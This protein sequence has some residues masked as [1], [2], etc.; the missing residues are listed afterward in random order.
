MKMKILETIRNDREI[1]EM[2]KKWKEKQGETG[3]AFPPFNLDEYAGLD[4]Y[5]EKIRKRLDAFEKK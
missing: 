5:K 2:K 1:K 4:D 3:A